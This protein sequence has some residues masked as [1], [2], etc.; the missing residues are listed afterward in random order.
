LTESQ[1]LSHLARRQELFGHGPAFRAAPG[2]KGL[3]VRMDSHLFMSPNTT[4]C[5]EL[6]EASHT[7]TVGSRAAMTL[8]PDM[9]ATGPNCLGISS[10]PRHE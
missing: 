9:S 1:K 10:E 7:A 5:V 8:L 3:N 6:R 2:F 4:K